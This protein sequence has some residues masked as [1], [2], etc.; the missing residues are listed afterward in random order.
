MVARAAVVINAEGPTANEAESSASDRFATTAIS[1][2][3]GA[4]VGDSVGSS[5]LPVPILE[6]DNRS[7]VGRVSWH[8][9]TLELTAKRRARVKDFWETMVVIVVGC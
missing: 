1:S 2:G 6:L 4:G 3:S 8:L 7:P 5:S 9:T